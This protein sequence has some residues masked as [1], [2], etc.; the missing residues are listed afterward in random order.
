MVVTA[1]ARLRGVV[2]KSLVVGV[3]T[4]AAKEVLKSAPLESRGQER[5]GNLGAEARRAEAS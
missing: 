1:V 5:G 2:V 4:S 3:S